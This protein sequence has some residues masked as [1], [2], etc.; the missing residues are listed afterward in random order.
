MFSRRLNFGY[1]LP[2]INILRLKS[3]KMN[4]NTLHNK[5]FQFFEAVP[6]LRKKYTF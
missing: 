1:T 4:K 3:Y 6:S 5:R 2:E